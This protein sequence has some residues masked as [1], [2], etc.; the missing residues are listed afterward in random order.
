MN[1]TVTLRL[2]ADNSKLV[3]A[4]RAS[5][6]E[7]AALGKAATDAGQAG[8]RGGQGVAAFGN[9]SDQAT[10][11]V[12]A[13]S[14]ALNAA[15]TAVAGYLGAA[16]VRALVSYSDE[17]ANI[18]GRLKLATSGQQAFAAAQ[19][20]VFAISQRTSTSLESTA[21]L[22]ARL[23]QSTAEYGI[24]QQRQLALTETINR[25]FTVSGASAV[26]ASNTIT[27]FTQALAGGVLRA[28]EFNSVIENSPRL[29]KA[30]A[31][32]LGVGMGELRKMV[33]DGGVSVDKLVK[34]LESQSA[35][36]EAEFNAM[37]LTVERSLVQLQNS[38]TKFVGEASQQFGA[39]NAI[40]EGTAFLAR[41]LGALDQAIGVVAIAFGGRLLANLTQAT[42]AKIA[43][44]MASRQLAQQELLAAR[45]AEVQAAGQLALARAGVTS[46][47]S[48][49]AAEQ[50][51][52]S[53]QVRTAAAAEAASVALTA[54]AV[55]MRALN[56]AMAAF[57]G[58]VGLAIT[59][60]TLFVMW[61]SN[62]RQKADELSQAVSAG[63]QSAVSTM[64][65]FNKETANVSFA[66]LGDAKETLGKANEELKLTE[67]RYRNLQSAA[68]Q[69]TARAG[70][71]PPDFVKQLQDAAEKLDQARLRQDLLAQAYQ[72]SIDVSADVVLQQAGI[73]NATDQ[74][75]K[76]LEKLLERQADQRLTLEQNRP[77]L[78]EWANEMANVDVA[79]RLATAS[80]S[81][82]P[83]VVTAA[84]SAVKAAVAEVS[85]D[86]NEQANK[87]QLKLIEQTQG[88]AAAM[89]AGF[90]KMLADQGI[91]PA[92]QQAQSLRQLN[93][94]VI[95][96]T[97]S[98]DA[99]TKK[100]QEQT[101]TDGEAKR[102][103]DKLATARREQ[104]DAQARY[105]AEAAEAASV[106]D[107]PLAAAE[108]KHTRRVME[109]DDALAKHKITQQSYNTLVKASAYEMAEAT[110]A[111][112]KQQ[113]APQTLLDSMEAEI[114][115]LGKV[116]IAR[117]R[118]T[119][120]ARNQHD[121]LE[122][123]T[124]ANKA[125]AGITEAMT[126]QLLDQAA[127]FADLSIVTEEHAAD[128]QEWA[129]VATRGTADFS[130]VLADTLSG[131]LNESEGFWGAMKDVFRRGWRDTVR[132]LLEQNLVRPIQNALSEMISGAF[133]SVSSSSSSSGWMQQ[134][135]NMV[136]GGRGLT[137]TSNTTGAGW[138]GSLMGF[139]NNVSGFIGGGGAAAGSASGASSMFGG[140]AASIGSFLPWVALIMAGM[141]MA[142][143]AFSEGFGLDNQSKSST[144]LRG[145]VASAGLLTPVM[146]DSMFLDKMG[147]LFGM[148]DKTA[149]IFSGSS[150]IG[151]AFG[152]SAPKIQASGITGSYGFDGLEGQAYADVKQKGGWFRSDKKW[153]EYA[154]LD[155]S[156]TDAFGAAAGQV[157]TGVTALAEGLGLDISKQLASVKVSIGKL[158]LDTD[159]EVAKQQIEDAINAMIG[160]LSGEAV[161][162]LGLGNL[163]NKGFETTDVLNSLSLAMSV[164]GGSVAQL[165]KVML[166]L[167]GYAKAAGITLTEEVQAVVS[168]ATSYAGVVA[169]AQTEVDTAGFSSFAKGLL[170]IRQ[171]EKQ[172]LSTLQ[173]QA[174]AL[175]GLAAREEDLATVRQAAQLKTDALV[176][177]LQSELADLAIN[178]IN[179]QIEQLGG[180]AEGASSKLADFI[181]SLKLSDTLS[182]DTD[183]Q[184]RATASDLMQ[185]AAAAG[186]VDSFTQYAQQFLE[187]SRNL[188]ASSAGYQ[189]DYARVLEIAKQF[190]GD[191]TSASL[192]QLYA[193]RDA[194]QAQQEAAARLERAQRIAQGVADLAGVNG[195]DPLQILRNVTG[196]SADDLAGD[197][198]LSVDGLTDYLT[199]QQTDIGD[200]A[201]ILY[202]LPERI[203]AAM[204]DALAGQSSTGTSTA[205]GA[206]GGGATND[207]QETLLQVASGIQTLVKQGAHVRLEA[208]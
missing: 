164:V 162:A 42:A 200:L 138:S 153:T 87:L 76:S 161:K 103:A 195:G 84:A 149:A 88:K 27:Q 198:G 201:D 86:L 165:G 158:K 53:A 77:R 20:E 206:V 5:R 100:A 30:L 140:A 196:M 159:P 141:Q 29:A 202:D 8:Q 66:N 124:D 208:M 19:S 199:A 156:I 49:V 47:G 163:L 91:D 193:Q 85:K 40:A 155:S 197:L 33:N 83:A 166:S 170:E 12:A 117:E 192:Q 81:E 167:E 123:I 173:A 74:Q 18:T 129:D 75:R 61:V 71:L 41:N 152:R 128:L 13:M 185:S 57:G 55:A 92:S 189:A 48:L 56:T 60:L 23:A 186:N 191:G 145:S 43:S 99:Y 14:S 137:A 160:T 132:T 168:A 80:F 110:K 62:S 190:G 180:S 93:E 46:A 78:V 52:A 178:R 3:P 31:D 121:M 95:A 94:Q 139:G 50:A 89:R 182:T 73:T 113:R 183:V 68:E 142:S 154:A 114:D 21:T 109:L 207:I 150:L 9:A 135:A 194:L 72:H 148:S 172:R 35:V 205:T 34:A 63:F 90:V 51:L 127:A 133:S 32:G 108:G 65:G 101:R 11:K 25:T 134:L 102:A 116:G 59:A 64:Q 130:D 175:H 16:A 70:A 120:E 181:N 54:K 136:G 37:P 146:L 203:A 26:A 122:A 147:Q 6:T 10:R 151:K 188:N 97:A 144:L 118:A 174:K 111:L 115:L 157:K 184:K 17:Y 69:W 176:Q 126:Q 82:M 79:N 187:V 24:S 22:Y 204:V 179:D 105:A 28:E 98:S 171:E 44:A 7:V 177:S 119:R 38:I 1:P 96:L 107:G 104:A 4:V 45:A 131:S 58:P 36:I 143:S 39:G 125:G 106:V 169:D 15:K 112:E 2:T 67:E